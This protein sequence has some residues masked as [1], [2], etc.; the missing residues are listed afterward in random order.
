MMTPKPIQTRLKSLPFLALGSKE[1]IRD[2][3]ILPLD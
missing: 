1:V 2:A 3:L